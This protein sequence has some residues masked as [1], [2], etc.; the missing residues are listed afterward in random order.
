M[1]KNVDLKEL[2]NL[3][4]RLSAFTAVRFSTFIKYGYVQKEINYRDL[5]IMILINSTTIN[6][7]NDGLKNQ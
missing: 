7:G 5:G 2:K 6:I 3:N 1:T 4:I